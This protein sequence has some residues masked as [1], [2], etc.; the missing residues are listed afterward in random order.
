MSLV[1]TIVSPTAVL[2]IVFFLDIV[3]MKHVIILFIALAGSVN[4][5]N[6]NVETSCSNRASFNLIVGKMFLLE[7]LLEVLV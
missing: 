4:F 6:V 7:I 3:L 1:I 2:A 5:R